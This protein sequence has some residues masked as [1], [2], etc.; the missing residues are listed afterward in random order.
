MKARYQYDATP[1]PITDFPKP[2]SYGSRLDDNW[3][4]LR[5]ATIY[6][7]GSEE[8]ALDA[9]RK[10]ASSFPRSE[11]H[12]AV[13]YMIAKITMEKSY[14][15]DT[16][17]CGIMGKTSQLEEIDPATVEPPEKCQDENWKAAIKAFQNFVPRVSQRPIF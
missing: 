3:A 6:K 10:H 2:G 14:S 16:S 13:L 17:K 15:F 5:A 9:F 1:M 7:S 12:E 8:E 11:K 4:Y